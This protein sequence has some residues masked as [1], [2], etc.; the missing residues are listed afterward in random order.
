MGV[1]S[2]FWKH[3]SLVFTVLMLE[4]SPLHE[5]K[6]DEASWHFAYSAPVE[7]CPTRAQARGL[8]VARLGFDPFV[9]A[10]SAS[11]SNSA[12][13][14]SDVSGTLRIEIS[15]TDTNEV[16][17]RIARLD[18]D[19]VEGERTLHDA[20]GNC[21]ELVA[22][23]AFTG[24]LLVDPTGTM[25]AH[26]APR[27]APAPPTKDGRAEDPFA[28]TETPPTPPPTEK[29]RT[30]SAF[31]G[32]RAIGSVGMLPA[33]SFGVSAD[34]GIGVNHYLLRIEMRADF[35]VSSDALANGTGASASLFLGTI[36]PCYARSVARFCAVFSGGAL[37]AASTGISP[38]ERDTAFFAAIGV[39]PGVEIPIW[40]ALHFAAD[41]QAVVPL[42]R[43]TI[44]TRGAEVWTAPVVAGSL[45]G[46]LVAQF[47]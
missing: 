47:L 28:K 24:S 7:G 15:R 2:G 26:Q 44:D 39:R 19:T 45:G 1:R 21:E 14:A 29:P 30:L 6:A 37:L 46:G 13:P 38:T 8:V 18:G 33:P 9:D 23:A 10:A 27:T 5:A 36:A 22:S 42:R 35:P 3:A 16:V 20:S 34:A 32:A 12:S 41:V 17:A 31:V 4:I 43:V 40:K 11:G 25:R